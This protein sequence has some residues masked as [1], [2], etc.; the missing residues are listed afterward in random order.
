MIRE[1]LDSD[2]EGLIALIGACWAE[3]DGCILDVDGE[4]PELR[5]IASAFAD[6]G[7]VFWVAEAQGYVVGSVGWLPLETGVVELCKL[8]VDAS[9]RRR[10]LGRALVERVE[11]AARDHRASAV[12]LWSDTRFGDAHRLYQRMGY[13]RGSAVRTLD[14]LS[15]SSEYHYR[16][17]LGGQ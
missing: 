13:R 10:G 16:K 8:Y 5:R 12:G 14:D 7:G 2:A 11:A 1:A 17:L 6:R 9:Q 15:R 4:V 3:Y